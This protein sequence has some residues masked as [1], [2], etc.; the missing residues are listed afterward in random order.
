MHKGLDYGAPKGTPVFAAGDGVV[1]FIKTD[2]GYGKHIKIKHSTK[3]STLYAHLDRF[4]PSVKKGSRVNQGQTIGFVGSTGLA[5][6]PHLHYEVL[7]RD[8][9]INP[10]KISFAKNPPLSG[11]TLTE[12]KNHLKNISE[13]INKLKSG[14]K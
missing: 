5:S 12:Y 13:K 2:R 14:G 3:Y 7:D 6:G 9:Q 1:Q 8:K 11:S 4:A 10:S